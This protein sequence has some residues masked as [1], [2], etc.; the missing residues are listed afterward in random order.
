MKS[1]LNITLALTTHL[2]SAQTEPLPLSTASTWQMYWLSMVSSD[3]ETFAHR[4]LSEV[5]FNDTLYF[6]V[7]KFSYCGDAIILDIEFYLRED[8]GKWYQRY[9]QNDFEK[10]LFDFT[11]NVGDVVSLHSWDGTYGVQTLQVI[12]I[13][14]VTMYDGSIRNQWTLQYSENSD[15]AGYTEI[16][17]EGMGNQSTGLIHS[18]SLTCIDLNTVLHCFLELEERLYPAYEFPEGVD[19]CT[20]VGLTE[21][22]A[23][24]EII[25][26]PNPATSELN[27]QCAASIQ[28]IKVS[29]LT[30]RIVFSS[31]PYNSS[32]KICIESLSTGC[33]LLS[34]ASENGTIETLKFIKD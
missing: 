31:Q 16:W 5:N 28:S 13:D 7:E 34:V 27:I 19:C 11:L 26:S 33:Y 2:L 10:L 15:L 29:D 6:P 12:S 1:I 8:S 22:L 9:N 24:A 18:L 17:I 21:T 25:L 32:T 4:L 14:A 30:G 23:S 3:D 20:P